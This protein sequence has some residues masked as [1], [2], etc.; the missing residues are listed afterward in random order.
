MHN[1]EQNDGPNDEP[2]K[3]VWETPVLTIHGDIVALTQKTVGNNDGTTFLGIA[4]GS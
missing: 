1:D 4:I 2:I 3:K